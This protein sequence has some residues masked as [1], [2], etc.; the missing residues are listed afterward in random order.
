MA[1]ATKIHFIY[2]L[3]LKKIYPHYTSNDG[4]YKKY[5]VLKKLIG[6]TRQYLTI[7]EFCNHEMLPKEL[8]LAALQ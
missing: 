5:R 7:D 8:V 4:A 3:D 6:V 1:T 2:P